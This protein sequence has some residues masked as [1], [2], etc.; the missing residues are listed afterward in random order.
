MRI[1]LDGL[2][3]AAPLALRALLYRP[4]RRSLPDRLAMLPLD[5]APLD[6][7]VAISWNEHQ[8]P[9]ISAGSDADLAAALGVV[10]IHLRGAQI[11]TM[12]RLA[13][14]RVSEI[15][16]PLGIELD[17][18]MRLMDFGRAVPAIIA[19]LPAATRAWA[20]AFVRGVN[21]AIIHGPR[22]PELALL[23]VPPTPWT[24]TDL[25]TFAR[26]CAA[27]VSW[28]VWTRLLKVQAKLAPE[29]WAALWPRLLAAGVP[30]LPGLAR[31]GSNSA[32]VSARRS[33]HGA[34][35]IASDPHLSM[36]LPNLWLLAG[37]KSP[38]FNACGMMLPGLPFVALG[39]NAHIAWGGTSL[40]AAS[41]D[42]VDVAGQPFTERSETIPVRG[43]PSVT[44]RLRETAFGPVVTDGMLLSSR[45]PAAL[46]WAGHAPSDELTAMLGVNRAQDWAEFTGALAGFAVPGQT[47]TYADATGAVG[48]VV[49]AHLPLRDP[50][51]PETLLTPPVHW[52]PLASTVRDQARRDPADGFVASANEKPPEGDRPIG[53]FFAGPNRGNRLRQVLSGAPVTLDD[54]RAVQTDRRLPA[55]PRLHAVLTPHLAPRTAQQAETVHVIRH[56]GGRYDPESPG[57]LAYELL[58]GH[59]VR[60][61]RKDADFVRYSAIW[62]A[63]TLLTEDLENVPPSVLKRAL[64]LALRQA[65][66][67]LR[68][69]GTWGAVHRLRIAH[70]LAHLPLAGHRYAVT[71]PSGGSNDTLDKSGHAP[72]TGRHGADFGSCARHVS[73]MADPNANEFV[74]LGGQDGWP[75]STTFADQITLW[76]EGRRIVIPL[77]PDAATETYPHVTILRPA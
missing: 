48:S 74:L 52:G 31:S 66:A 62:T 43:R 57:A 41:S 20:E 53:L 64:G 40:H 11:E 38:G 49:A 63:R 17:R 5:G 72:V 47:M 32:A 1:T 50:A 76:Q 36:G 12:R 61:L 22:P 23:D 25:L 19:G 44:L 73:D 7:P 16:G 13:L 46:R 8:V 75:G 21:H 14:G 71:I 39:R 33:A 45:H 59:L 58:I 15:V 37:L 10:H 2:R 56:W 30:A 26:L 69:F 54:M 65:T 35:M 27:D 24:L 28:V 29:Q 51:P 9:L 6:A 68:R 34:A 67:G 4:R 18:A 60:A 70:P 3:V 42:L 55:L 77:D